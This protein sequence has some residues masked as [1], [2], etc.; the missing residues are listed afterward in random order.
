MTDAPVIR[1]VKI[2]ATNS[3]TMEYFIYF[4]FGALDIL[5][6]FRLVLKVAGASINSAFVAGIYGLS[7]IFIWPF[8]GIFRRWFSPGAET[9]S[10]FEP[11]TLIAILVYAFLLVNNNQRNRG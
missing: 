3:Q 1:P 6:A 8:E 7:G 10:V 11:S 4:F 5:L 2:L 9:T